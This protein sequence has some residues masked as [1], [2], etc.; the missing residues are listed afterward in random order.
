MN[1]LFHRAFADI[2][3]GAQSEADAIGLTFMAR[4]GYDPEEAIHFWERFAQ[5][6][7]AAGGGTPSFL[8]THPLDA[9][10]IQ[11]LKEQLPKAMA[12]YN[13]A[14]NAVGRPAQ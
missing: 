6:N 9:K 13:R 14:Q 2:L 3:D 4:A 8:R 10:R 5:F 12:E 7:S 11:A 1:D